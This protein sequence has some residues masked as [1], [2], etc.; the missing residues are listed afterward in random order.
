MSSVG[1]RMGLV[2]VAHAQ[3]SWAMSTCGY[4]DSG[5]TSLINRANHR[6]FLCIFGPSPTCTKSLECCL[7][8]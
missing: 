2:M 4:I 5:K 3:T 1:P 8:L 6:T 7:I